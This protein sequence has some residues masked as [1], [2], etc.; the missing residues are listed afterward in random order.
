MA[1]GCGDS[2]LQ[3]RSP[4]ELTHDHGKP[5]A[6]QK[7]IIRLSIGNSSAPGSFAYQRRSSK[8]GLSV[9]QGACPLELLNGRTPAIQIRWATVPFWFNVPPPPLQRFLMNIGPFKRLGI[10]RDGPFINSNFSPA[11]KFLTWKSINSNSFQNLSIALNQ[12]N[13]L[14]FEHVTIRDSLWP[15]NHEKWLRDLSPSCGHSSN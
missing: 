7:W 11:G 8:R 10:L 5:T 13:N 9:D 6:H 15:Q 3:S 4:R 2:P 12:L 1:T 14:S